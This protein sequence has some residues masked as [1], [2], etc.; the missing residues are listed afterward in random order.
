MHE[1]VLWNLNGVW[2]G[3][4]DFLKKLKWLTNELQELYENVKI[5]YICKG[6]FEDE[7]IKIKTIVKLAI[8]TTM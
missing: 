2:N 5:C 4:I 6:M 3:D 7:Y 8:V 1:K